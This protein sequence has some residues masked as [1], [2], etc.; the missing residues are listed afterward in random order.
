MPLD[1]AFIKALPIIAP[2]AI[3]HALVKL[4]RSVIPNPIN[5]GLS[6][7]ESSNLLKDPILKLAFLP[8]V[9]DDETRYINPVE[10]E[11]MNFTLSGLVSGVISKIFDKLFFQINF[12]NL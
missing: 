7:D 9:L 3:L 11:S 1:I 6:I 4:S 8:V 12:Y 5:T 2:S 10:I